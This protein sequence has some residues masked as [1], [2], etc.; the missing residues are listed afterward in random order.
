MALHDLASDFLSSTYLGN[1]GEK[2]VYFATLVIGLILLLKIFKIYVL[3]YLRKLAKLSKTNLDDAI[4]DFIDEIDWRIMLMVAIVIS[5][6]SL[7]LPELVEIG[8]GHGLI[9]LL[10]YL[11]VRFVAK[12]VDYFLGVQI[13]KTISDD[14]NEDTT[15]VIVLGK[16]IKASVWLLAILFILSNL[17]MNI[18][19][20][21][22]GLGVG[23]IAIAFALQNILEDL[24][25]SF[26]IYFDKPFKKGD[27]II[28][29][30]DMGTV[31][32]IGI[33]TTRIQTLEGQELVISNRELTSSRI[34]NYKRMQERRIVFSIGVIYNTSMEK[35][36]EAKETIC[37]VIKGID[38]T[39]LDRV[40]FKKFGDSSLDFEV[41]YYLNTND[42]N[43]YM[44]IQEKINMEIKKS[45]DKRGIEFAFPT[46]TVFMHSS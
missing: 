34:N 8:L 30:N 12:V 46:R 18:T 31:K 3:S 26:T 42:Y 28:V 19:S 22:A 32:H 33:K 21:I 4:V 9:I 2:Y 37:S 40:N 14:K 7:S 16:I 39:R 20:L 29:G 45:F 17:G 25:S 1:S 11:A 27:F 15:A 44:E 38:S 36:K 24:F 43:K 41:V 13:Q 35:L 5:S 10:T 6:R 23:G